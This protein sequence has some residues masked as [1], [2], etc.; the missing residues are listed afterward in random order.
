M[1]LD[2]DA[3]SVRRSEKQSNRNAHGWCRRQ[4][5]F[6]NV[7]MHEAD[8]SQSDDTL[9]A[10][11]YSSRLSAAG[12]AR[13]TTARTD[14]FITLTHLRQR[15][16]PA[17]ATARCYGLS[18]QT[19]CNRLRKNN[20]P[21]CARRPYK[22]QIMTRHHR[23]NRVQWARRCF[24]WRRAD[25]NRVLFSDESRFALSHAVGR[26]RVYHRTNERYADCCVLERDQFGGGSLMVWV[27]IIGG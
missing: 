17:T 7:W 5:C 1:S 6:T 2:K 20:R 23:L 27:G 18:A 11:W 15:F 8:H 25:W 4:C 9:C 12:Q 19:V 10:Y 3:K 24:I 21:I 22:G 13:T 26:I 14:Q 16:L